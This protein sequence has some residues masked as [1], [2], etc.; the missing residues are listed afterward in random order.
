MSFH[1]RKL[2]NYNNSASDNIAFCHAVQTPWSIWAQ[3]Q[4][5][6]WS[7]KTG[8]LEKRVKY[9][10]EDLRFE[11]NV[12][13]ADQGVM[14]MRTMCFLCIDFLWFFFSD[15]I[16]PLKQS[17][18]REFVD[19]KLSFEAWTFLIASKWRFNKVL[20]ASVWIRNSNPDHHKFLSSFTT[21]VVELSKSLI[22]AT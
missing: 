4:K 9:A 12:I 22:M 20:V 7:L 2:A 11:Q 8:P 17:I 16:W 5:S 6:A 3:H 18:S 21:T 15:G 14:I 10:V 1:N 19:Q 13:F